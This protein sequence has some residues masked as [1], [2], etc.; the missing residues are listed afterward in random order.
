VSFRLGGPVETPSSIRLDNLTI[1]RSGNQAPVLSDRD[2]S[3]YTIPPTLNP[4]ADDS[5]TLV[6]HLMVF[7]FSVIWKNAAF[8]LAGKRIRII[9]GLR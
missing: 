9:A 6:G 5:G 7:W 4:E 8:E 3:L 1:S 2:L